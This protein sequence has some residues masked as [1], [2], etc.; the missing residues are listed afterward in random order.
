MQIFLCLSYISILQVTLVAHARP[1]N[2]FLSD[3]SALDINADLKD[4]SQWRVSTLPDPAI[5][6]PALDTTTSNDDKD[7]FTNS[8]DPLL[9]SGPEDP[10]LLSSACNTRSGLT[11]DSLQA[12]GEGSCSPPKPQADLKLP[13]NIYDTDFLPQGIGSAESARSEA[14]GGREDDIGLTL[15]EAFRLKQDPQ[16][17]PTEIFLASTTPVCNNPIT[18]SIEIDA[19]NLY[20]YM[21][22]LLPCMYVSRWEGGSS[23]FASLSFSL[24]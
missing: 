21:L 20:R 15:P 24:Y 19:S 6:S 23:C 14:A 22:N 5:N 11:D 4:D 13:N 17:C 2:L 9:T 10:F 18:G 7:L 3:S 8:L 12:R 1:E 16:L